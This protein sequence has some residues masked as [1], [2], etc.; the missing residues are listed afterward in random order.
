MA[1]VLP[2][3]N[4]GDSM[5]SEPLLSPTSDVSDSAT[6]YASWK[7]QCFRLTESSDAL[8]HVL[9]AVQSPAVCNCI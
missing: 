7:V 4:P 5:H 3:L 9:G 2:S 1:P 6:I 8:Q